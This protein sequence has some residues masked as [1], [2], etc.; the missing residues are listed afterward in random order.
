VPTIIQQR[1]PSLREQNREQFSAIENKN[2]E[3]CSKSNSLFQF[4]GF[5]A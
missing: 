3:A 5:S 1:E 4:G 2:D